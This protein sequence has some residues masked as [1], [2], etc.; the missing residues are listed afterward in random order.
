MLESL[1]HAV[2]LIT[3][4]LL[5]QLPAQLI[6]AAVIAAAGVWARRRARTTTGGAERSGEDHGRQHAQPQ[7]DQ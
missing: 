5:A 2:V 7:E 3:E 1:D 4:G 6:T